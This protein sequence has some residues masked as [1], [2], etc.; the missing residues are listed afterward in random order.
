MEIYQQSYLVIMISCFF[1][2]QVYSNEV[3][4][5]TKRSLRSTCQS[6]LIRRD[7]VSPEVIRICE[8]NQ[9]IP[10]ELEPQLG[11]F[12][13]HSA[14]S[15]KQIKNYLPKNKCTNTPPQSGVYW[16][17][18]MQIY[19]DMTT[20]GGGWTLVW[21]HSYLENLPLS[22]KMYYFSEY[23][24]SCITYGSG[25]CNIP[26]KKR[27]A[28]TEQMIVAY[29]NRQVIYAYKG[30]FNFNIDHDWTGGILVNFTKIVDQCHLG[31][32]QGTPPAPSLNPSNDIRLFG[33]AFDKYTP[34]DYW[35][36]SDTIYGSFNSPSDAR[37]L[38]C[39]WNSNLRTSQQTM[40]IYVR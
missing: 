31:T 3:N 7:S 21:Q 35:Q 26:D 8:G 28:P 20:D 4:E 11:K 39:T 29:H 33:L 27:F 36:N 16:I 18:H 24:K 40:A 22:T 17:K 19:C 38:D 32:S 12:K 23:L 6:G 14:E 2:M 25:W 34:H 1:W 30:R 9:W 5:T 10:Y 37:F 13:L 15:C